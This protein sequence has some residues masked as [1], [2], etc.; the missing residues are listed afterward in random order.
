LGGIIQVNQGDCGTNLPRLAAGE[1]ADVFP[2]SPLAVIGLWVFALRARFEYSPS[3]ELPWVWDIILRP[4][5]D[6][7][8]EPVPDGEPRKLMIE[9]SYNTKNPVRNYRPAIFVGRG[10]GQVTANK[11]SVNNKVGEDIPTGFE[12]FHCYATMPVLF[13]CEAETSGESSSIAETAWAFVLST[14]NIFREDFGFHEITSPNLGDTVPTKKDKEIWVTPV[15]F[16]VQYDMRWGT[17]PIAPKLRD[18][19]ISLTG[20]GGAEGYFVKLA[21]HDEI[22]R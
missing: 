3:N 22:Y 2:G 1:G 10:G 5:D 4:E 21:L 20:A 18:L 17:T 13:N 6:E 16:S 19:A 12:A 9:S 8:G 14:R 15:Q 7:D 11:I